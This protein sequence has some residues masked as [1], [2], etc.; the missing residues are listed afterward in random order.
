MAPKKTTRVPDHMFLSVL[1]TISAQLATIE[2]NTAPVV[3]PAGTVPA[4]LLGRT[5]QPVFNLK[6]TMERD[7]GKCFYDHD[8]YGKIDCEIVKTDYKPYKRHCSHPGYLLV[9][10]TDPRNGVH[11]TRHLEQDGTLGET[12]GKQKLYTLHCTSPLQ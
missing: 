4:S 12:N 3:G 6:T 11:E 10:F 2:K 7:K 8:G 9:V 5:H 1:H